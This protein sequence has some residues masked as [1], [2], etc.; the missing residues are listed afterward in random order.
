M[1]LLY[2]EYN[3]TYQFHQFLSY[4]LSHCTWFGL[5]SLYRLTFHLFSV[6][7]NSISHTNLMFHVLIHIIP[8]HVFRLELSSDIFSQNQEYSLFSHS[9]HSISFIFFDGAI[10]DQNQLVISFSCKFL[11]FCGIFCILYKTSIL[12]C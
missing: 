12:Y 8:S 7:F 11:Y 5:S 1:V 6:T 4:D 3:Q 10:I 9:N 2:L